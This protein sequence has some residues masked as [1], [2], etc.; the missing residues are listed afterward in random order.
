[1]DLSE[2]ILGHLNLARMSARSTE[3]FKLCALH[4]N[5]SNTLIFKLQLVKV[6]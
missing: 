1:M 2:L 3:L 4:C 5:D 6:W